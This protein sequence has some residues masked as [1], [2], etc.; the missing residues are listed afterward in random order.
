MYNYIQIY[1]NY[2][3]YDNVIYISWTILKRETLNSYKYNNMKIRNCKCIN[4]YEH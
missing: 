2:V 3:K 1:E 4:S